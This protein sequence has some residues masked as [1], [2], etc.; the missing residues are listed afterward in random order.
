MCSSEK[1]SPRSEK[2]SGKKFTSFKKK[3]QVHVPSEGSHV[4]RVKVHLALKHGD[5]MLGKILER[6][7]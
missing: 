3:C 7:N 6:K 5:G 2:S 4:M 1:S